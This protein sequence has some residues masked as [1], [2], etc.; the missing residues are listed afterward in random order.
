MKASQA[1]VSPPSQTVEL[2]FGSVNIHKSDKYHNREL[3]RIV[4][5]VPVITSLGPQQS[6]KAQNLSSSP[7]SEWV[8]HVL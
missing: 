6:S 8:L 7:E 5:I 1:S 4:H 2:S 3:R